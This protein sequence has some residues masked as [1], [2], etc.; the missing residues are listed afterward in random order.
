V[1]FSSLFF[2]EARELPQPQLVDVRQSLHHANNAKEVGVSQTKQHQKNQDQH[3]ATLELIVYLPT[4]SH[5]VPAL[6]KLD[7]WPLTVQIKEAMLQA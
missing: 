5:Q 4:E 2:Y 3:K 7:K 1:L 6:P